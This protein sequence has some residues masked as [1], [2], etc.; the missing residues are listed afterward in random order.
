ME[1]SISL[2]SS[3]LFTPFSVFTSAT[4]ARSLTRL[5]SDSVYDN[6]RDSFQRRIAPARISGHARENFPFPRRRL[7]PAPARFGSH[8]RLRATIHSR[9]SGSDYSTSTHPNISRNGGAI[10]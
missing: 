9:R 5:I 2:W 1:L 10:A 6:L 8:P 4:L 3:W 7:S